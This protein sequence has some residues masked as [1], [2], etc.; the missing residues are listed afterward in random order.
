MGIQA[1]IKSTRIKFYIAEVR[2]RLDRQIRH[3]V[4]RV[5]EELLRDTTHNIT[6]SH[7]PPAS[8]EGEFP[9]TRT[10]QLARSGK[11]EPLRD[12]G[13]PAVAV[14]FS[15]PH[16]GHVERMRPF[17]ERTTDEG[18]RDYQNMLR[19]RLFKKF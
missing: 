19:S 16:A 15:A 9:H 1:N 8:T 12:S 4:H 13:G 17:L 2:H 3:N 10:G 14:K 6:R 11:T 18:R 5:A 7:S